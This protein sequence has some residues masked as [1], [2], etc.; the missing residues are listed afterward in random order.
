MNT[1]EKISYSII[2]GGVLP[3]LIFLAFWWGSLP[4]MK[5]SLI[6][7]L[8]LFGLFLGI[9][10]DFLVLKKVFKKIYNLPKW[11]LSLVYIFYTICFFGFFMGV[12]VF[13][14]FLA[15]PAGYYTGNKIRDS[16]NKNEELKK[17]TSL[18]TTYIMILICLSS[19][20]LALADSSTAAN[21]EGMF[22]LNFEVTELMIIFL[23]AAGGTALVLLQYYFTKL[24]IGIYEKAD[25]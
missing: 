16:K 7:Y 5:E 13:N 3:I 14:I 15:I 10:L 25:R 22:N 8:A 4:F 9:I 1:R 17:Q 23:I 11:F 18:F 6:F 24:V 21:L 2:F 12:P 19:A 20:F